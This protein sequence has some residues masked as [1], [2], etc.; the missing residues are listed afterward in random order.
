[1]F[2]WD[3]LSTISIG[4]GGL[5]VPLAWFVHRYFKAAGRKEQESRDQVLKAEKYQL[6]LE[7]AKAAEH[8]EKIFK[9][10]TG[11]IPSLLSLAKETE[12]NNIPVAVRWYQK[13]AD[14][15]N[16]IAQH[17]LA[18]LCKLDE[19]DPNGEARSLY[20]ESFI[21]AKRRNQEALF[22]LGRYQIRGYGTD[23]N[24]EAGVDNIQIAATMNYVPA[25]LFLGDWFVSE[26]NPNNIPRE[27]F[28]W[29]LRAAINH[30]VKA[31]V[32][33]AYCYQS[34]LGI[35]KDK[36]CAVYWLERA[37]EQGNT[38]AQYLAAKMH[39][40]STA[41]DA[42]IAYIWLSLA[43][44]GGIKEAKKARDEVVQVVGITS[45]LEVQRLTKTIYRRISELMVPEH[46]VIHLIDKV[47]SREGY[48]PNAEQLAHL[49]SDDMLIDSEEFFFAEGSASSRNSE[50]HSVPAEYTPQPYYD[51]Q[52][53]E[54]EQ[55]SFLPD[56]ALAASGDSV[57]AG[58]ESP[59]AAGSQQYQAMNW[60]SSWHS[61][62]NDIEKSTSVAVTHT[63]S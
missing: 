9:A 14:L 22:E 42:A 7:K 51:G 30:D 31:F 58:N 5:T 32:K 33:L 12:M 47:Y 37:A 55:S 54:T 8:E 48:R 59:H 57:E 63:P 23:I 44:A 20:W 2:S 11:H 36:G 34:G 15:G 45:I 1:M 53:G 41:N 40:G 24:I 49:A 17:S 16:E 46:A 27:A 29:R 3:Q 18:R 26:M 25:Q 4:I 21:K 62:N 13:A 61:L 38:E 50:N 56:V 52:R 43:Y 10:Q 39:L 35:A 28:R 19:E 60:S 6:V